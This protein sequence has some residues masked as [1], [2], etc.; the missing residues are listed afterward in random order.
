MMTTSR[1]VLRLYALVLVGCAALAGCSTA[2][3][4][5]GEIIEPIFPADRILQE[6]V[7]YEG[8]EII[9]DPWEGF[10]RSMYRFNYHFDRYVFLPGVRAYKAITPDIVAIS[11]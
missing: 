6:G 11:A 9:S 5:K 10:N 8:E 7:V 3:V 1:T 4:Q 2:P